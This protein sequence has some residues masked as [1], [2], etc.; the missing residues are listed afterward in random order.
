MCEKDICDYLATK[1]IKQEPQ[2]EVKLTPTLDLNEVIDNVE[3]KPSQA[4]VSSIAKTIQYPDLRRFN[5]DTNEDIYEYMK[6]LEK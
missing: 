5:T 1:S 4:P 6:E 3:F 2:P